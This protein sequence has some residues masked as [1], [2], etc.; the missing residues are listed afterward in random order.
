MKTLLR[1]KI[2]LTLVA[3]PIATM[4]PRI[5]LGTPRVMTVNEAIRFLCDEV[6]PSQCQKQNESSG[7]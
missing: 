5:S 1:R 4:L 7:F 6:F 2:V 3:A